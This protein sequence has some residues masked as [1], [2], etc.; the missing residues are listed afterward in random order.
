MT[1]SGQ[2]A[3]LSPYIDDLQIKQDTGG[4]QAGSLLWLTENLHQYN[5]P[6]ARYSSS[7]KKDNLM[8]DRADKKRSE[9]IVSIQCLTF[10]DDVYLI[11]D[12]LQ[13]WLSS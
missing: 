10:C 8:I 13:L 7:D 11:S 5:I 9:M 1:D 3:L 2:A 6:I 4:D 12:I